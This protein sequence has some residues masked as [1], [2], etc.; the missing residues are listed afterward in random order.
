MGTHMS[1]DPRA[2]FEAR[3]V[4][5][6]GASARAGSPGAQML[7]Q[8]SGGGFDGQIF[9][10]NP[11]YEE[12]GG[13]RCYASIQDIG[14]R[15]DLAILGVPNDALLE[16]LER[17]RDASIPAAV[18]FA[19]GY[20]AT[21]VQPS[22]IERLTAVAREA[23]IAVCGGNCMGFVDFDRKLRALAFEER[24]DIEPGPIAWISH[25]GSAFTALL[26]NDRGL[27]FNLAVSA[28]QEFTT[29]VG[30]YI[31]YAVGRSSTRVVALFLEAVRDPDGF[32]AALADAAERDIPV[33]ALKVGRDPTARSLITAH[34]G[35][36]AGEDAVFDALFEK[37]GVMRVDTLNEMADLLE[38][39]SSDRR[40]S[41][42][43]LAAIHD[44]GGERAHLVDVAADVGVPFGSLSEATVARL[45]DILEAGLPAVNPL[46]AWGTGR[47]YEKIFLECSRVLLG[48]DDTG[49][50]AFVVDLAGEDLEAGYIQVAEQLFRESAVPFAVL[51]NLSSAMDPDAVAR[52]RGSGVPV[53]EDTLYGL[54][55]FRRLFELRD[56]RAL[57]PPP[58][59]RAPADI[60]SAW[61]ERLTSGSPISEADGLRLLAD[62][63]LTVARA[64]EVSSLDDALDR[65][66]EL[67][68]PVALK[69]T[70]AE[71]KSDVGG[72]SLGIGN[73]DALLRAYRA[74][75]G[76]FGPHLVVQ[77]MAPP[78]LEVALGVVRDDQF[79]P[80]TI[81]AAGGLD[82][83]VMGDRRLGI[84]PLDM[85]RARRMIDALRIRPLL[86]GTR[87]RPAVDVDALAGALVD[88]GTLAVDLADH[89]DAL[90]VNPVIVHPHGCM[91]VDALVIPRQASR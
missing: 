35:A 76:R 82:V 81:V 90:D 44:S 49:A 2:L 19:S 78:G 37:H 6:V 55:A 73:E 1:S 18:I 89:L 69:M 75:S 41:R 12:I 59:R 25:S 40:P 79:G 30:D 66:G 47:D 74:M 27:G 87:G 64:E 4:A 20:E 43:G 24:F 17:V 3:S 11:R 63:G 15:V 85:H 91:A 72:V 53:L 28:G 9:P 45:E 10:V 8:L 36:L 51:S 29:T 26:H 39:L 46:D 61:I 84:P 54:R 38:L 34:S 56:H 32:V 42:G 57:P 13:A 58:D 71:H 31:S 80:V 77:E 68:Y 62:Y 5:V 16:Q 21:P 7:R 50:F 67:G 86:D 22:L 14:S 70:A 83:E 48:N 33:V 23:G 65:A 52:L 88:V 60:R